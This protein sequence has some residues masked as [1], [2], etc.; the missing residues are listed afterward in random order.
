MNDLNTLN[1]SNSCYHLRDAAFRGAGLKGLTT[2]AILVVKRS[3]NK[4]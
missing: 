2:T 1:Q 4:T 3:E